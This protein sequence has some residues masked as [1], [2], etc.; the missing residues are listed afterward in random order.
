LG[1]HVLAV[2]LPGTRFDALADIDAR[3][4]D[5]PLHS[6]TCPAAFLYSGWFAPVVPLRLSEFF[7]QFVLRSSNFFSAAPASKPAPPRNY[8]RGRH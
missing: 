4:P 2:R 6:A 5:L 7:P 3:E 1:Q 8:R